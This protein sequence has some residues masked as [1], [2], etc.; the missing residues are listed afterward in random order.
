MTETMTLQ[1]S[2]TLN[3]TDEIQVRAPLVATF[4]ALLVQMGPENETPDGKPLPMTLE[5]RPGGR[6]FR[7][8]G[9]NDGHLWGLVQA[10]RRPT[11]LEIVGPLFMSVPVV[12]NVQYRLKEVDGGTLISFRHSA[13]GFVPDDYRKGLMAGWA[14]LFERVR[15]QAEGSRRT[16]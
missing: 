16:H 15:R 10:I 6:W 5:P 8:L 13:L 9:G 4:D 2:L 12:S 3:L 7:D 14:P 1:E 11:L